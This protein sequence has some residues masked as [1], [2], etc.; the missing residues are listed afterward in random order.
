MGGPRFLGT[1]AENPSCD[2]ANADALSKDQK[3]ISISGLFRISLYDDI[4]M[5]GLA[6][7]YSLI[8]AEFKSLMQLYK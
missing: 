4:T 7:K 3:R 1:T 8:K 6:G 5:I 2:L